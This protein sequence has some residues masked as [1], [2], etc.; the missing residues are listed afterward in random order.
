MWQ[1]QTQ[2]WIEYIVD[3]VYAH[4]S[5][6]KV[7]LWGKY[8]VSDNIQNKLKEKYHIDTAFYV[9]GSSEKIDNRDVFSPDVL[10]GRS[11]EYYVVIPLAY[12]QSVKDTLLKGGYKP[13]ADYF[14]FCDCIVRKE[15]DYYE[16]AHGNKIIGR[17]E[18][19]KFAFSGFNSVIEIGDNARFHEVSCY[20][21]SNSRIEIGNEVKLLNTTYY[22]HNN[23][24]MILHD[25]V[26][27]RDTYISLDNYVNAMLGNHVRLTGSKIHMLDSSR[28]EIRSECTLNY[29]TMTVGK[30]AEVMMKEGI[31]HNADA[32]EVSTWSLLDHSR[33]EIGCMGR[34]KDG[35]LYICTNAVLKIG[36]GFSVQWG[37]TFFI[38]QDT[39]VTI[40][41]E[42]M[43]SSDIVI[44][45]DD[46][47][48]IFDVTT[49]KNINSTYDIRKQRKIVIENHVWLGRRVT[50]LYNSRIAGGSIIVAPHFF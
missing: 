43:F 16:D 48:S 3:Y 8:I 10:R 9:D 34:F 47:H 21:H 33:L 20:V 49:G 31:E 30:C 35:L 32:R 41:A 17:Y 39:V 42:C 12:Y 46:A 11:A 4:Y 1:E 27:S 18:G 38:S 15:T 7:V 28:C 50:I 5:G 45:S 14:Y 36:N 26:E 24:T 40:G 37:Y 44:Q 19:M 13:D 23:S 2:D 6:R 22:I 25:H 29:L